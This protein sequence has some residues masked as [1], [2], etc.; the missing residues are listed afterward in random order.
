MLRKYV[1]L[2]VFLVNGPIDAHA[3]DP[4]AEAVAPF[5]DADVTVVGR[6]NIE[7]FDVETF[8]GKLIEDN[9]SADLV[10]KNFAPGLTALRNAGVRDLYVLA[11]LEDFPP[12]GG[13]IPSGVA[14]R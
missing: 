12:A 1:L 4:R 5:L 2:G 3:D 6:I 13:S 14:M 10:T 9:E 11:K 7:K 8:A